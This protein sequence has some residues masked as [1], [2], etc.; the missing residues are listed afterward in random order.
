[1]QERKISYIVI[2]NYVYG[3][4][5][6]IV[7]IHTLQPEVASLIKPLKKFKCESH[8]RAHITHLPA[9]NTK[10]SFENWENLKTSDSNIT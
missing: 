7:F 6:T 10:T 2:H 9:V 8:Y 1:M 5:L 3:I 4:F